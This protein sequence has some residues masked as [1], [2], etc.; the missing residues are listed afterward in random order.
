M[1]HIVESCPLTKLNGG[2]SRLHSADEDALSWLTNHVKWHAYEKKKKIR[3]DDLNR[4]VLSSWWKAIIEE[5]VTGSCRS[6]R[7]HLQPPGTL[8]FPMEGDNW[9]GS[10]RFLPQ[11]LETLEFLM[12]GDNWGRS[13]RFLLQPPGTLEFLMEGDNWGRSSRFLLQPPGTDSC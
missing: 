3:S 5:G 12:E 8:E 6:H 2:L 4:W 1:S 11:P 13:S 10:S 9:G 7:E